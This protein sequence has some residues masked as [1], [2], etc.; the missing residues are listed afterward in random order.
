MFIQGLGK[1]IQA[2]RQRDIEDRL[3]HRRL[4]E[5]G[6]RGPVATT[7]L[8]ADRIRVREARVAVDPTS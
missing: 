1:V 4:I 5:A 3:R 7:R 8:A 2:D 6:G